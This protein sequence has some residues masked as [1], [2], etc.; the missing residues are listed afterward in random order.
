[1]QI[2]FQTNFR[3]VALIAA[4]ITLITIVALFPIPESPVYLV[5]KNQ[6][7]KARSALSL[8]RDLREFIQCVGES[9]VI[10]MTIIFLDKTDL[11]ID[12]EIER[13]KENRNV[14][15]EKKSIFAVWKEFRH[16]ELYKPFAIMVSFFAIQQFSGVFVIFVYAAQFSVEAGVA[17]DEFLSAVMIG[18]IRCVTTVLI[19]FI[20][21]KYGKKPPTIVSAI[22]MFLSMTGLVF[23]SAFPLTDTSFF[24]LP[25]ALLYIFIFTGTLGILTFPF[26]MVAEMYPQK[27]R[28][29][30]V[31]ITMSLAWAMSFVTIKT[32]STVFDYFGTVIVF[33]FYAFVTLIGIFFAIFILPETKGKSLREIEELFR[34]K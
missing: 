14:S 22:G 32:F 31:G 4:G 28:S 19:A 33:S 5:T 7:D 34:S 15:T 17:I 26:A 11:K 8:I 6:F 18:L 10:T 29:F 9:L 23:C 21:D 12:A 2:Y 20:S 24:W 16:P 30:A 27:T 25:T 1:M 3:L 13:I